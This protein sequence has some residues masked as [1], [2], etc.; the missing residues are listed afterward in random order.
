[1]HTIRG[2][3]P[4]KN[5]SP[6]VAV[7]AVG[8]KRSGGGTGCSDTRHQAQYRVNTTHGNVCGQLQREHSTSQIH[9]NNSLEYVILSY[10][11]LCKR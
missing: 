3:P 5:Y 10:I 2:G 9:T 4:I 6:T 7:A 11:K 8:G 1:M